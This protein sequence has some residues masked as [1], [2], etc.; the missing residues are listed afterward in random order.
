MVVVK[1]SLI[2]VSTV[3]MSYLLGI[4]VGLADGFDLG[5]AGIYNLIVTSVKCYN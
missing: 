5:F 3:W 2:L 1:S 4:G